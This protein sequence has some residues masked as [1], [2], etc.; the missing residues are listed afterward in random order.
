MEEKIKVLISKEEIEKRIIELADEINKDYKEKD[1]TIICVLKGACFFTV[2]LTMHIKSK[3]HYEFLQLSSYEGTNSSGKCKLITDVQK[4]I[5]G[6][7]VLIIEDIIDTGITL[8][9]LI[10]HL[11]YKKVNS[12]KICTLLNKEERREIPVEVDYVGFEI[13]N[14]FV[15]GYGLDYNGYYRNL[16]YIGVIGE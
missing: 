4:S 2:N 13:P 10:N 5:E 6:K 1:F 9:F 11:K 15:I 3:I 12:I 8:D 14:K 16:P 7:D